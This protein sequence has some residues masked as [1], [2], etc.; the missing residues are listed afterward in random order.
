[1]HINTEDT[2]CCTCKGDLFLSAVVSP[3]APGRAACPEHAAALDAPPG[4]LVLLYRRALHVAAT[5]TALLASLFLP[6]SLPSLFPQQNS[7]DA[8]VGWQ[9]LPGVATEPGRPRVW[10]LLPCSAAP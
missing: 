10:E 8:L 4:S 1:M 9:L 3:A 7:S 5:P 2:D 6:S